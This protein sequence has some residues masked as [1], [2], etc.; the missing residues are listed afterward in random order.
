MILAAGVAPPASGTN[1]ARTRVEERVLAVAHVAKAQAVADPVVAAMAAGAAPT[2]RRRLGSEP[3]RALLHRRAGRLAPTLMTRL[4]SV[5]P[6]GLD[7]CLHATP[8]T[9]RR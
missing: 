5:T 1:L 7:R 9:L 6:L 8:T 3:R 2:L 4:A